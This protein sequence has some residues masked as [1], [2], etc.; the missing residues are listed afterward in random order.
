MCHTSNV[1]K[2]HTKKC[3]TNISQ[4]GQT[5]GLWDTVFFV[6]LHEGM[7]RIYF[8]LCTPSCLESNLHD[9]FQHDPI[10]DPWRKVEACTD[11]T[12]SALRLFHLQLF[13]CHFPD[14]YHAQ[15]YNQSGQKGRVPCSGRT[16]ISLV[17][18][19]GCAYAFF[20]LHSRTNNLPHMS[21]LKFLSTLWFSSM[22]ISKS[23]FL[24]KTS[25]HWLH[26]CWT[27]FGEASAEWLELL[28][29]R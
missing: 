6:L 3:H 16:C 1:V 23:E 19:C 25:P 11:D 17:S 24:L 27:D 21:H 4:S 5:M 15:I 28:S 26:V 20:N 10:D 14:G 9:Q 8:P 29:A 12:D 2:A 18:L 13:Q 7:S 22:W